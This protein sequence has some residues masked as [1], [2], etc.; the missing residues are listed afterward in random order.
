MA[1]TLLDLF[2]NEPFARTGGQTASE[3]YEVRDSKSIQWSSSSPLVQNTGIQ[4]ANEARRRLG[5]RTEETL[6]EQ[7]TTGIRVVRAGSAPA[8]YGTEL[9]RITLGTTQTK[10]RMLQGSFG[11]LSDTGLLGDSVERVRD[12]ID[13]VKSKLGFPNR[14]IPTYVVDRLN[15]SDYNLF[16]TQDRD[17]QLSEILNSA[18]GTTAG[19]F[20]NTSLREGRPQD[21]GRN[22]IGGALREIKKSASEILFGPDTRYRVG[23]EELSIT[24]RNLQTYTRDS[25]YWYSVTNINYGSNDSAQG[26]TVETDPQFA[27]GRTLDK[28]GLRYSKTINRE[29]VEVEDRNDLST[30]Q[31]LADF[32]TDYREIKFTRFPERVKKFEKVTTNPLNQLDEDSGDPDYLARDI[33]KPDFVTNKRGMSTIKDGINTTG[34]F[35]SE[36]SVETVD[37]YELDDMDFITLKFK[38]KVT[39]KLAYFRAT[40]QGLS[41]TF[42]PEWDSAKF[43]G[44]PFSHYTYTGIERSVNFT[45][46]VFSLSAEEHQ[47]SWEKLNFLASLVY[48]QGYYEQSTAVKP[49]FIDFTLGDMYKNRTGFFEELSFEVDDNYP[50]HITDRERLLDIRDAYDLRGY[51]T[52]GNRDY[53]MSNYKLPMI[54]NVSVSIKILESRGNT[55]DKKFYSFNPQNV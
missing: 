24:G 55:E 51:K 47:K 48:P 11:E 30:K 12:S 7:E 44:N 19:N 13:N 41:E 36:D 3:T 40:V 21:I 15:T 26:L 46:T 4:I 39:N 45:F 14:A 5:N 42:T 27:V 16:L 28:G 50:W 6:V 49:P 29:S 23:V 17:D 1:R 34:V 37:G 53:D 10:D 25:A 35:D 52:L 33:P 22:V 54:I 18:Q 38:S 43:L 8:L 2:N 31:E 20:L 32:A 9:G